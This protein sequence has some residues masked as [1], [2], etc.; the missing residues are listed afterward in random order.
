MSAEQSVALPDDAELV[1]N[2]RTFIDRY[3]ML[4]ANGELVRLSVADPAAYRVLRQL[5]RLSAECAGNATY[6]A[7]LD[8]EVDEH[9]KARMIARASGEND[10]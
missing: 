3:E 9:V 2:P 8:R 5:N 10:G 6:L 7:Q 1:L 4:V